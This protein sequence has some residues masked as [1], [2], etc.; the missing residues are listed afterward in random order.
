MTIFFPFFQSMLKSD[1]NWTHFSEPLTIQ[2]WT[3]TPGNDLLSLNT[4]NTQ[5]VGTQT[6][7]QTHGHANTLPRKGKEKDSK[8]F[9]GFFGF[10]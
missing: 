8:G 7:M 6:N 3:Q 5:A 1:S 10:R 4:P 9:W 2:T